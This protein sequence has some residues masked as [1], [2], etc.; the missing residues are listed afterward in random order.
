[1]NIVVLRLNTIG[2]QI[3]IIQELLEGGR[4]KILICLA[5]LMESCSNSNLSDIERSCHVLLQL[6]IRI[7]DRRRLRRIAL[8]IELD[9]KSR[10]WFERNFQVEIVCHRSRSRLHHRSI[11]R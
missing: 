5:N 11:S 3:A 6:V 10:E 4:S 7:D 1:M 2:N 8:A 9:L